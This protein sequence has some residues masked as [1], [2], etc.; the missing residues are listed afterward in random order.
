MDDAQRLKRNAYMR[1][2]KKKNKDKVNK[3]NQAWKDA[4]R[5]LV[6]ERERVYAAKTREEN[7]DKQR[8]ASKR[9]RE[10]HP[11]KV[12]ANYQ[13]WLD[14]NP[15][16]HS[17]HT[18]NRIM[19][20]YKSFMLYNCKR[21]AEKAGVAFNIDEF[22][23]VIPEVCPVLDIPIIIGER[24]RGTFSPN[25]PSVDRIVPALGYIKGNILIISARANNLKNNGTPEELEKVAAYARRETDRVL[26]E[27]TIESLL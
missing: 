25:S 20:N 22:D 12:K 10:A 23:L 26:L 13:D 14:R 5:D 21:R 15:N 17:N 1:E 24:G 16:Y 7:P 3:V 19:S 8:E 11:D 18:H 27:Q 2:W 9:Y 4:N 6:R